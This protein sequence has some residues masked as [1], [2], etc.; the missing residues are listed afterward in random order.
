[1]S[2]VNCDT[3]E[4]RRYQIV[5]DDE[6]DIKAGLISVSSPFAR[7]LIGKREGD[8]VDV[9]TPGGNKSYEL[10]AVEYI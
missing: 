5:G 2:L 10:L 9:K 6:A 7:A 3:D 4:V 8:E 1:M